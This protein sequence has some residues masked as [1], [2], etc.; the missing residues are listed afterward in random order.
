MNLA[1]SK[2]ESGRNIFEIDWP[3]GSFL[4]ENSGGGLRTLDRIKGWIM[5]EPLNEPVEEA[6]FLVKGRVKT[7]VEAECGR[8]LDKFGR[9]VDLAFE[10]VLVRS[11]GGE[12]KEK[13]LK[14]EELNH[15]LVEGEEID[16]NRMV[17]EQLILDSDMIDL[18]SPDCRGLCPSC[19]CNLN[20]S[21]CDC[22]NNEID[23]RL[24]AL[25]DWRPNEN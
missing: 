6:D 21:R 7:K 9:S 4:E 3:S 18:C 19:G 16:L 13:E 22:R 5:I 15:S 8:C 20:R 25:A 23:P 11:L 17:C 2:I 12:L 10:L 1:F 24:A 14:D